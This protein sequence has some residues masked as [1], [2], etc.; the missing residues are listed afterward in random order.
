[1]P[2]IRQTRTILLLIALQAMAFLANRNDLRRF[3]VALSTTP[4]YMTE[5][6]SEDLQAKDNTTPYPQTPAIHEAL[7]MSMPINWTARIEKK[8]QWLD[9][10]L[11]SLP[12]EALRTP[13]YKK[14]KAQICRAMVNA[15]AKSW[16]INSLPGI[17][18]KKTSDHRHAIIIPF[19]DRA[20]HLAR[21]VE[22][23]SSYLEYHFQRDKSKGNHTF[24]LYIVEQADD[25][26]F[27]RA[28]LTNAAL[29][30]LSPETE[31][32]TQHDVDLIPAFFSGIPYHKCRR[33]MHLAAR[34]EVKNFQPMHQ[35]HLGLAV[36]MHQQHWASINGMDH[37]MQGWG[38]EDDDLYTRLVFLGLADCKPWPYGAPYRPSNGEGNVFTA[39][40]ENSKH[41]TR[42]KQV[43][44]EVTQKVNAAR[45]KRMR[46]T[47][48]SPSV[49]SSGG[50]K[51]SKYHVASRETWDL[52]HN[53]KLQ[54][55]AEIHHIKI[56]VDKSTM[57]ECYINCTMTINNSTINGTKASS[58]KKT[59]E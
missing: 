3:K 11:S 27:N 9:H 57:E 13:Q 51:Q 50:W 8:R 49:V 46:D 17:D 5:M 2:G 43:P 34:A 53:E 26:L 45:A 52:S 36:N 30:H 56:K 4:D 21:F 40:S 48:L 32:V 18:I 54:G 16:A 25:D 35:I 14:N 41:H 15:T 58:V 12:Q 38:G 19:R 20:F 6:N 59:K 7:P 22:Y 29:D 24:A 55:F 28:L 47:D 39:I 44:K 1:M 31:C 42:S 10:I 33:P 37:Q 23:M